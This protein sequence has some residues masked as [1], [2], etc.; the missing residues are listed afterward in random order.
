MLNAV[1]CR[2]I[3]GAV[4]GRVGEHGLASWTESGGFGSQPF[5]ARLSGGESRK[6]IDAR[7]LRTA[8]VDNELLKLRSIRPKPSGRSLGQGCRVITC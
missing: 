2:G 6:V 3:V 4:D 7:L 5:L 1:K 8:R